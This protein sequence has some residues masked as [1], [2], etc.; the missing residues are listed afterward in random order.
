MPAKRRGLSSN[1]LDGLDVIIP[2][3]TTAA[4]RGTGTS[5]NTGQTAPPSAKGTVPSTPRA[6][7]P[8]GEPGAKQKSPGK[9]GTDQTRTDQTRTDQTRPD[10]NSAGQNAGGPAEAAATSAAPTKPIKF[11]S[12][13]DPEIADRLRNALFFLGGDWTTGALLEQALTRE[14]GRLADDY[15]GGHPFPPRSS[16]RLRPGSRIH[17]D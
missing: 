8:V 12:Y 13:L 2:D 17:R 10:Q 7:S 5:Q 15:N 1:G 4:E 3:R 16:T 14:L 9:T 6:L 11:S